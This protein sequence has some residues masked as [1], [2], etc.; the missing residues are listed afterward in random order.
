MVVE[1]EGAYPSEKGCCLGLSVVAL[2][3]ALL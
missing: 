3:S 2:R 1:K